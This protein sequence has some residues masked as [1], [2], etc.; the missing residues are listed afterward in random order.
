[1]N[2]IHEA[3][4]KLNKLGSAKVNVKA[5]KSVIKEGVES[6]WKELKSFE[7]VCDFGKGSEWIVADP[8]HGQEYFDIYTKYSFPCFGSAT[9]H[10]EP[11]PNG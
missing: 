2:Y 6:D 11:L 3:L 5:K 1:M 8:K 4:N 9:I 10:S 7:E